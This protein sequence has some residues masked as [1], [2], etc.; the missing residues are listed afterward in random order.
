MKKEKS[1]QSPEKEK[2]EKKP[3]PKGIVIRVGKHEI[4]IT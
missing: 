2:K 1:D 4:R 3:K